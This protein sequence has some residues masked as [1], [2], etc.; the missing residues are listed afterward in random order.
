MLI[1]ELKDECMDSRY[2]WFW[3]AFGDGMDTG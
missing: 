3:Y 1:G 2:K